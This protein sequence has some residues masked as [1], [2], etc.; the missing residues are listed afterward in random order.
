MKV[1][2]K[3]MKKKMMRKRKMKKKTNLVEKQDQ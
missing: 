1:K 3:Q 2:T